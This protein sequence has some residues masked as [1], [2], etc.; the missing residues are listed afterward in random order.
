M[1]K[2]IYNIS[3]DEEKPFEES[4]LQDYI[5]DMVFKIGYILGSQQIDIGI[6]KVSTAP[7]P[8]QLVIL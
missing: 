5:I 3:T 6:A 2:N 4:A 1:N 7:P 8:V